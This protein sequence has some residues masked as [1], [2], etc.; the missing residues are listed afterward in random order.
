MARVAGRK[1][2]YL[3]VVAQAALAILSRGTRLQRGFASNLQLR[4]LKA[5]RWTYRMACEK[6]LLIVPTRSPGQHLCD[7]ES[8]AA[9]LADHGLRCNTFRRQRVV[10]ASGG[11]NVGIAGI[12]APLRRIDP[13]LELYFDARVTGI[14]VDRLHTI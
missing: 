6:L 12:P 5:R 11:M 14:D 4:I 2:G 3:H 7:R 1:A 9:C 10:C 13:A 8:F